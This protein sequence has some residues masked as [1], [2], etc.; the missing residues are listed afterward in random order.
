MGKRNQINHAKNSTLIKESKKIDESEAYPKQFK[1]FGTL[2]QILQVVVV[3]FWMMQVPF[4]III[5][6]FLVFRFVASFS[7]A[8]ACALTI[9]YFIW[10]KIDKQG[11]KFG[12]DLRQNPWFQLYKNNPIWKHLI[13]YFPAQIVKTAHIDS[14][15][16][17]LLVY[18]P[19]G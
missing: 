17:Y 9:V 10:I 16:K 6:P 15:E 8:L 2:E 7:F 11:P 14:S 5:V 1:N 18:H 19:H 4:F 12:R 13:H 3:F